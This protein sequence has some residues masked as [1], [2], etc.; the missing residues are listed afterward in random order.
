MNSQAAGLAG[1]GPVWLDVTR[2]SSRIGRGA[3]TGI[4]RV[5]IAYLRHILAQTDPQSRFLCRTT[6]GYLLLGP[7]GGQILLDL[8]D[9]STPLGAAD[10]FS[11]LSFRGNRPRHRV[12]AAIRSHAQ[13]R[14]R[15]SRLSKMLDRKAAGPVTY[16]N[17]GHSNLSEATLTALGADASIT[18]AV[19]LHDLIPIRHPDLVAPDLPARFADRIE[20]VRRYADLVICNS[21]STQDDL[22]D[23]WAEHTRLPG[24]MVAHLGLDLTPKA[25]GAR[26]PKSFVMLGTIEPRKNHALMLDVWEGL[27][28]E[29]PETSMPHLN[30]IGPVGWRVDAF[31]DRLSDH[32]LLN[33]TVHYHG[34]LTDAQV[35]TYLSHARALLFPSTAE[36]YGYPPL[37]AAIAG[38]VPI[39]STLPVFRE[40]LGKS[41]VYVEALDAYSWIA[42]IRKL[43]TSTMPLPELTELRIPT[44]QAHFDIVGDGLA[45]H[46]AEGP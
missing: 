4:D 41:A 20:R 12:E 23:H 19:L 18:V 40:T 28:R 10:L 42:T 33:K 1:S 36:G 45:C 13:D 15:A 26:D 34:Q 35:A 24:T 16:L 37:E 29:L 9:G 22:Q 2:L 46:R 31:M 7:E 11:R 5:E 32:P 38:A 3:L 21:A 39:C 8:A 44:W 43:V 14:C 6:R 30:I 25:G 27:A 17:V